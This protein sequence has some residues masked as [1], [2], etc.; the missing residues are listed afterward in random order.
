MLELQT[1]DLDE[2][3]QSI[4]EVK[5]KPPQHFSEIEPKP[6]MSAFIR[7]PSLPSR[8]SLPKV[9]QAL[10]ISLFFAI[11]YITSATQEVFPGH[12]LI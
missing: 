9:S 5:I 2:D 4:D 8:C 6:I 10:L 1:S 7:S 11:S 3:I 12:L